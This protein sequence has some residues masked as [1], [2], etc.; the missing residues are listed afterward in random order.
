MCTSASGVSLCP[1][2][3]P[4]RLGVR[5]ARPARLGN[6]FVL[7]EIP[8]HHLVTDL[9]QV[10]RIEESAVPKQRIDHRMRLRLSVPVACRAERFASITRLCCEFPFV[11]FFAS[12]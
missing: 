1:P 4:R 6:R 2:F 7:D 9:Q 8:S 10:A 12:C 3:G 5:P 11:N